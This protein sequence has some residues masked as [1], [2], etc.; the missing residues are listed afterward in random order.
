LSAEVLLLGRRRIVDFRFRVFGPAPL[1]KL[2]QNLRTFVSQNTRGNF[3]A[4]VQPVIL[5][6]IV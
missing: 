3:E 6:D 2:L 4:M 1:K 5:N